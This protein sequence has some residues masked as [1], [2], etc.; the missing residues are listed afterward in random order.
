M[1][2]RRAK[3]Y[4]RIAYRLGI[5]PPFR[6]LLGG[7]KAYAY[8]GYLGDNTTVALK[9]L[10]H[11]LAGGADFTRAAVLNANDPLVVAM[12]P[13]CAGKICF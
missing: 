9:F 7:R 5:F 6:Q 8:Q 1:P 12:E 3:N 11:P 10:F 13:Y 4:I 2:F